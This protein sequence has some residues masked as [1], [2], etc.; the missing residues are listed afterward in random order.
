VNNACEA[1]WVFDGAGVF[2]PGDPCSADGGPPPDCEEQPTGKCRSLFRVQL[3]ALHMNLLKYGG[4]PT[5]V[6]GCP[7]TDPEAMACQIYRYPGDPFDGQNVFMIYAT[8]ISLLTDDVNRDFTPYKE[9][10]NRINN[11][12]DSPRGS[13]VLVCPVPPY[14]V[15]R[16]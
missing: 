13:R 4:P 10:I 12:G 16:Y 7:P 9:T 1:E 6:T 3:L 2:S 11:N 14:P 5:T 15:P 8:M